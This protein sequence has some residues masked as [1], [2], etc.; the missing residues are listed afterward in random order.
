MMKK[1]AI[2]AILCYLWK[3]GLCER[4]V[5]KE[6]NDVEGR[7]TINKKVAQN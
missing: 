7:G 2:I 1:I 6:I 3:K 5:A 4:A